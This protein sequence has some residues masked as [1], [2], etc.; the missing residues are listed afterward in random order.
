MKYSVTRRQALRLLAGSAAACL[1]VGLRPSLALARDPFAEFDRMEREAFASFDAQAKQAFEELERKTQ[2]AFARV[3]ARVA[4]AWGDSEVLL[5]APKQWVGYDE[6]AGGRIAA[7]YDSG[8]VKL[9]VEAPPG[10]SDQELRAKLASFAE[11]T[12]ALRSEQLDQLDPIRR[13]LGPAM[14]APK[15]ES[16]QVREAKS[17]TRLMDDEQ[18]RTGRL[19]QKIMHGRDFSKRQTSTAK[20]QKTIASVSVPMKKDHRKLSAEAILPFARQ[21]AKRFKMPVDLVLGVTECESA[22]NPR[23]VSHVPAYGLMQLV[24]RSGGLDAYLFVYGERKIL[25]TDYLF[26]PNQNVE[27]GAAYLH[28]LYYRYLRKVQNPQSRLYCAIAGYN[29]GAGNVAKAFGTRLGG[30]PSKIS[31]YS[32]DQVFTKLKKDL[33][34][35]ETR[36]YIVKV[37]KAMK[38]YEEFKA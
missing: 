11:R 3:Q 12:L 24:P 31:S 19:T 2:Q 30:L 25:D 20:G 6:Q 28:L 21:Y 16:P 7:D 23:A 17:I 22:F 35:E 13:D 5:P 33:P 32:P 1:A 9:E 36:R 4:A 15:V 26:E 37:T 27:L 38:R 10:V 18:L 14:A 29:T 8:Q 34:Y